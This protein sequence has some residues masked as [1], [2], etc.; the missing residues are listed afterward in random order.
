MTHG[1]SGDRGGA[2][3]SID[4]RGPARGRPGGGCPAGASWPI[5]SGVLGQPV[6][7]RAKEFVACAN[8]R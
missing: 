3:R 8:E 5:A 7:E 6:P 2:K 4:R 1:G